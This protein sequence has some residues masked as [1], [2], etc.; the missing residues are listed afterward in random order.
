[1]VVIDYTQDMVILAVNIEEEIE[2]VI[3]IGQFSI[4]EVSHTAD[5]AFAVRDDWQGK[6]VGT[7]LM[8]YLTILAKKR[9]LLGFTADV[10]ADNWGMLRV[11]NKMGFNMEK[12]FE[13]GAYELRM[14][15]KDATSR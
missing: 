10:L 2:E 3:G 7:E 12:H 15:F 6:G 4:D 11:F 9:G 13:A 1:M 5:V 14:T 8:K